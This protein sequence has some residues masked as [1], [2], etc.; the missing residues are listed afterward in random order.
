MFPHLKELEE[1]TTRPRIGV[2]RAMSI[3][4]DTLDR[5]LRRVKD[6]YDRAEVASGGLDALVLHLEDNR[7]LRLL[8]PIEGTYYQVRATDINSPM[9]DPV[10]EHFYCGSLRLL[11][12]LE[13]LAS[14]AEPAPPSDCEDQEKPGEPL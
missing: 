2:Y 9:E 7:V 12:P 5:A 10:V 8:G 3:G 11:S 4:S 1:P 14:Q 6:I 13:Q